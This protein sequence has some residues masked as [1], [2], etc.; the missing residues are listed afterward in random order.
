VSKTLEQIHANL[1]YGSKL[2][3][4]LSE[5]L[6]S[7]LKMS[8]DKMSTRY[9][10]MAESE[11]LYAAY[12]SADD[13]D[14]A[15]ENKKKDGSE[16]TFTTI[17]VPYAYAAV[18]TMHTYISS[19][20]LSRSPTYQVSARH[21]ETE[22]SVQSME[23]LLDYQFVAGNHAM[24][25]YI[26]LFDP[27]KYGFSV[28]GQYWDEQTVRTR[29]YIDKKPTF[30][31][32]DIPG[33]K[34]KRVAVVKDI[35]GYRGTTLYNVRPQD[36]FPD[37]RYPLWQFQ[38]GEFCARYFELAWAALAEDRKRYFNI[39]D[40]VDNSKASGTGQ[41]F[42]RDLGSPNVSTVPGADDSIIFSD[43]PTSLF[44]GHEVQVRLDPSRWGLGDESRREMWVFEIS[45]GGVIVSARPSGMYHGNFSYDVI[46][47]EPDGY[48]L[49]PTAAIERIKPLNDT[50]SWLINTHFYN[51][52]ASLNNK[53]VV[54]PSRVVMKDLLNR[55]AGGIIRLKPEAYGSDL[56]QS[57]YQVQT[58]DVT[59]SHLS[60]AQVVEMMI[61]RTLGSTDNV[62]GMLGTGG[63]KTA[64]EVRTSTSFGV[65]R[66]KT[67]CEIASASG[68][69]PMVSKIIANTQ[70]FY[71]GGQR[72]RIVGDLAKLGET[73][74]DISPES[75]AGFYDYVPV[76]GTLPVDRYA[77]VQ[78][79]QNLMAQAQKMPQV[80]AQYDMGKIFAW[81][82]ALGGLKNIQQFKIQ[83]GDPAAL[84]QQ[85]A[86]GNMVPIN[87]ATKDLTRVPDAG[88]AEGM[89]ATG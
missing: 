29:E 16:Q 51:V 67:P 42:G 83:L 88:R 65:S 46:M 76:D 18:M 69:T 41:G 49:L 4:K 23:A 1:K 85:A 36:F 82:A 57:F 25:L 84:A 22:M 35:P 47:Y 64:T 54:D 44:K 14:T 21:G 5:H 34:A 13:L 40:A 32:M 78:L 86:A 52:R 28:V 68:F 75:I 3:D 61:Q 71:E 62:M 66:L 26:A 39:Q 53:F 89:G 19:V 10:A 30:L 31:G 55:D 77:Q 27:L 72:Y 63:R 12:V 11:E 50:L 79:W 45:E 6:Q 9:K 73:A 33:A 2:H 59:R 24:P 60:D 15:K 7:R 20:F 70:Q 17:N 81:V 58:S 8:R 87:A 80:A 43:K 38:K 56:R 37:T 48:N 74:R